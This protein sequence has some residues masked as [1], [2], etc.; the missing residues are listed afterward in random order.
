MDLPSILDE[1]RVLKEKGII[2]DL[3]KALNF[4]DEPRF[5]QFWCEPQQGR[6]CIDEEQFGSALALDEQT[7]K[8]KAQAECIERY[9][10]EVTDASKLVYA[11]ANELP[12]PI[13]FEDLINFT[14]NQIGG[15]REEYVSKL[16]ARR[17]GWVAGEKVIGNSPSYIPAQLVHVPYDLENEPLI[18][19]PISTG[20]AF[21]IDFE[22]ALLRGILEVVERDSFMLVYLSKQKTPKVEL[23]GR[24]K[25]LSDYFK[26][27]YLTLNVFNITSDLGIPSFMAVIVDESGVGPS[28]SVGLK[29]SLNSEEAALV[30]ILESQHVRQWIR[31]SYLNSNSQ[32]VKS[33]EQITDLKSR[34]FF[35]YP[36]N[37]IK[38]LN[39]L[40]ENKK[41]QSLRDVM[42][43]AYNLKDT[44]NLMSQRGIEVYA[45]DITSPYVLETRF[46]VVKAIIP[47][48]HPLFLEE[49]AYLY[50]KRLEGILNGREVNKVPHPFI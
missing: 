12:N 23:E 5:F 24:L 25:E 6:K 13:A 29:S 32:E 27:Y 16:K 34:G 10:L 4:T 11:A 22:D 21:G 26:R 7:A 36:R 30:A 35:W 48:L 42:S 33:A 45:V 49:P 39:F 17:L 8:L 3:F 14:E 43:P 28:I 2:G 19:S 15:K 44:I 41:L 40:L 50:S 46:K 18:R 9:C 20:A 1:F 31:Y 38:E 47:Q 37:A